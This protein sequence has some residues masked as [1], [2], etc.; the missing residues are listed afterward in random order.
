MRNKIPKKIK[1][2]P[3]PHLRKWNKNCLKFLDKK[4]KSIKKIVFDGELE[5]N[6]EPEMP[7]KFR[8][9]DILTP[10]IELLKREYEK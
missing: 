7:S 9:Y 2:N 3:N 5:F 6:M 1:R 10:L 8:D 4:R